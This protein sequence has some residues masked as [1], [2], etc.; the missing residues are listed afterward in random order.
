MDRIVLRFIHA[1]IK[2]HD[3]MAWRITKEAYTKYPSAKKILTGTWIV[4]AGKIG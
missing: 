4:I 3:D 1:L 2:Q